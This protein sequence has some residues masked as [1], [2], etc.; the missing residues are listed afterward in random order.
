MLFHQNIQ[1][2]SSKLLE[3]EI[4]LEKTKFDVVCFTEHWLKDYQMLI[5]YENYNVG[6]CFNRKTMLR[7][8]SLILI[9]K[10]L[11]C[12]QRNDIVS[13]SVEHCIELSCVELDKHVILC[14]YRP[15]SYHNIIP[16]MS[17]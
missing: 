9:K 16:Y 4:F 14:V 6:S 1:G 12:K 8:G 11:K 3:I 5:N 2:I 15:P 17:L 13:L 10:R 7:G